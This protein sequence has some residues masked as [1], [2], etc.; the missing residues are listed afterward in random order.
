[1]KRHITEL[2]FQIDVWWPMAALTRLWAAAITRN[3]LKMAETDSATKTDH[4]CLCQKN[5]LEAV[6]EAA[7]GL[8]RPPI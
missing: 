3:Y 8:W 4:M 2:Y 7:F 5:Q 6:F 1:M